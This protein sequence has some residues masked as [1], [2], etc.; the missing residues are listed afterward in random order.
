M[1]DAAVGQ[2]SRDCTVSDQVV[3]HHHL[4]SA[5]NPVTCFK[6]FSGLASRHPAQL[7]VTWSS[8][9]E[10]LGYLVF[11]SVMISSVRI[12]LHM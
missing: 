9:V 5:A 8:K 7:T 3:F 6:T 10:E 1:T 2:T 12:E 4:A 11:L